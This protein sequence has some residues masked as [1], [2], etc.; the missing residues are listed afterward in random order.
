MVSMEL[1][2][3]GNQKLENMK[4]QGGKSF[5]RKK[6]NKCKWGQILGTEQ[7]QSLPPLV[8]TWLKAQGNGNYVE[9]RYKPLVT[10]LDTKI[11]VIK[12]NGQD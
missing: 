10:P 6:K 12:E 9:Y 11:F 7:W 2:K 8:M 1:N 4:I 3:K 5:Q